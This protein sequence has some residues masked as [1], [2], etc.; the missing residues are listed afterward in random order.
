MPYL[1]IT[2]GHAVFLGCRTARLQAVGYGWAKAVLYK[3]EL[4]LSALLVIR[5]HP[6]VKF[7]RTL[8]QKGSNHRS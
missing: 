4:K 8:H 7:Y 2:A 6:V 1:K 5:F 3:A